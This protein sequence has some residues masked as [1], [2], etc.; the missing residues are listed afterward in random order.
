MSPP[1]SGSPKKSIKSHNNARCCLAVTHRRENPSLSE[2][3]SGHREQPWTLCLTFQLVVAIVIALFVVYN[4]FHYVLF[5]LGDSAEGREQDRPRVESIRAAPTDRVD[6][7]SRAT[8]SS[9]DDEKRTYDDVF[10]TYRD[11]ASELQQRAFS[12][13]SR[14]RVPYEAEY[15][16]LKLKDGMMRLVWISGADLAAAA[17]LPRQP[18]RYRNCVR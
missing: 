18:A 7:R 13:A 6:T 12:P 10:G 3:F 8:F 9:H 11:E 4:V 16:L 15:V 17:Y 2:R 5:S 1:L 14:F